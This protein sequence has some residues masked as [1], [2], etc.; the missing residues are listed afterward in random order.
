MTHQ[1]LYEKDLDTLNNL[2]ARNGYNV[3]VGMMI[4]IAKERQYT[5]I[6]KVMEQAS[7]NIALGIEVKA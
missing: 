5:K 3:V 4:E 2:I 6:A 7:S 1:T